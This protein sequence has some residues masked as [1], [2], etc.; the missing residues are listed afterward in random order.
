MMERGLFE[1]AEVF[2]V[3]DLLAEGN[4]GDDAEDAGVGKPVT[5]FGVEGGALDVAEVDIN[6]GANVARG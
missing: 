5:M 3:A 6:G 2:G 1:V 4:H